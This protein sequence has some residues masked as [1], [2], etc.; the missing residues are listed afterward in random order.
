[1]F[2]IIQAIHQ[3]GGEKENQENTVTGGIGIIIIHH[4]VRKNESFLLLHRKQ[5]NTKEK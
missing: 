4:Q 2:I 3:A 5:K 1:M